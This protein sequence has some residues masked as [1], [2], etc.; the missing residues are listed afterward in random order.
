MQPHPREGAA[1]VAQKRYSCPA[2]IYSLETDRFPAAKA[3][4]FRDHIFEAGSWSQQQRLETGACSFLKAIPFSDGYEH[5]G[6]NSA[7]V[8]NLWSLLDGGIQKFAKS[9]FRILNLP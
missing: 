8:Y 9:G 4:A 5:S 2:G 1:F 7:P 6:F 3:I